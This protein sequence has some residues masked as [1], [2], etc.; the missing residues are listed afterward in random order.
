MA[1]GEQEPVNDQAGKSGLLTHGAGLPRVVLLYQHDHGDTLR[2]RLTRRRKAMSEVLTYNVQHLAETIHA[3]LA[4]A[5]RS[6]AGDPK[7][8]DQY[9]TE[10][11][12]WVRVHAAADTAVFLRWRIG[13]GAP[14]VFK[15]PPLPVGGIRRY[16]WDGRPLPTPRSEQLAAL[17]DRIAALKRDAP[18]DA[19]SLRTQE[20][21][22]RLKTLA[23]ELGKWLDSRDRPKPQPLSTS[24]VA[25]RAAQYR[26]GTSS[27]ALNT[28]SVLGE[29]QRACAK[30][31][32]EA[33]KREK[34][35]H[36]VYWGY[37]LLASIRNGLGL[38][39]QVGMPLREL[40]DSEILPA[41]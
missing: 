5:A 38:G 22:T 35:G 23:D 29:L 39:H 7:E 12:D 8:D 15:Q 13:R 21:A 27:L 31:G 11:Y 19:Q 26:K 9:R 24:E 17:L 40:I 37:D 16:Q 18:N 2:V 4:D 41:L 14:A 20:W 28:D 30:V 3:L 32:V 1:T 33:P 25:R 36:G 10:S 34:P 6:L